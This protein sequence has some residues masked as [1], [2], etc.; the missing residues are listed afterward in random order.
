MQEAK[1]IH[2]L[3]KPY[4][5]LYAGIYVQEPI[6]GV[7]D[8]YGKQIRALHEEVGVREVPNRA[9][10]NSIRKLFDRCPR[11]DQVMY[12]TPRGI[13]V[14]ISRGQDTDSIFKT[15]TEAGNYVS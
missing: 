12:K 1:I 9:I 10:S 11:L 6:E 2:T 7:E 4:D 14:S 8:K 5:R 15:L 3:E 13:Y